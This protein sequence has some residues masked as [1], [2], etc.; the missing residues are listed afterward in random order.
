MIETKG[1]D[2][3][4][5]KAL[6]DRGFDLFKLNETNADVSSVDFFHAVAEVAFPN[7]E[8]KGISGNKAIELIS[9]AIKKTFSG[10]EAS[11]N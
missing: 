9:E 5:I 7:G 2:I 4:Q 3:F 6:K 1:L 11:K 10:D 8:L